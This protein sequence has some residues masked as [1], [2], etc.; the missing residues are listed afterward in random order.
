MIA[1]LIALA[2]AAQAPHP[3]VAVSKGKLIGCV[4]MN[5]E[6]TPQGAQ[7]AGFG[8]YLTEDKRYGPVD[9]SMI[10]DASGILGPSGFQKVE[11]GPRWIK[12]SGMNSLRMTDTGGGIFR[13][14]LK[15]EIGWKP[16]KPGTCQV[17][18]I[19]TREEA[20]TFFDNLLK[21]LNTPSERG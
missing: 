16:L 4:F 13:A 17:R 2:A 14:D 5:K 3:E 7:F 19:A 15:S 9:A 8:I 12:M 10:R 20:F 6:A 1:V 11:S 18:D 21:S